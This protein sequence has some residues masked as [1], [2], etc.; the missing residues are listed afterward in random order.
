MH[1]AAALLALTAALAGCGGGDDGGKRLSAAQYRRQAD[2]ICARTNADLR[3]LDT[4]DSLNAMKDFVDEAKPIA[5]SAVDDFAELQPP[6][7]LETAHDRWVG[8]NRRVV[9]LLDELTEQQLPGVV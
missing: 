4:P 6:E 8:Q 3:A 1:R 9:E 2:A 7:D 5:Q